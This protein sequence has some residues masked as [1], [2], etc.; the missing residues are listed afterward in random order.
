MNK[1]KRHAISPEACLLCAVAITMLGALAVKPSYA[2]VGATTP[3]TSLEAEAG[4][5]GAG[6]SMVSLTSAPATQFSSPELEASGHAYVR[7]T[8]TGQSVQWTNNT[9]QP[10][11][12]INVR[13]CIPDAPNGGGI[14]AT[15]NLYV[16]GVFRQS[17]N[18]NSKQTWIYE[19]NNNYQGNDQ[20]PADGN[21]HVFWDESHTFITGAPIAP[22]STF[23][24]Q[25]DPSN[26]A[27][28]YYIDVIDVENPPPPL[29]QPANSISIT[30]CGAVADNNPTNGSA[31][32]NTVDSTA[33]IQNCIN[34]AQAQGK[35]LWIPPGTFY[36]KG[37]AGLQATGIT[38][39]GAGMW[40]STIYRAVPLPNSTPLAAVF[41]VT[42]CKVK[43]F[44]I[45][46]NAL[47][48]G[49]KDGDGG[50]MDT[51]G[52]NWLADGMWNQHTESGFWASGTS[53]TVQ[54]SRLTCIWA[55]GI[56]LNNVAL[57]GTVGNNLTATNNFIRG[58]G[59]DALA[60]NSVAYN[61]TSNGTINYTM[62]SGTTFSNNTSVA[63]WQGKGLAIYGGSNQL[64]E[65]NLIQDSGR[66][67][68]L[69][70][71][72]FGVN[73]SDLLSATITG[74]VVLRCG[75]NGFNQGQPAFHIGNGGDG[76]NVGTVTQVRAAGNTIINSI[77]DSFGISTSTNITFE[78]N[79]ITSPGRNGVVIAPPFYQAPTGSATIDGN[80]LTGLKSGQSAFLNNS[81]GYTATVFNNSWQTGGGTE[82][83][84][85][86]T[87]A[88][89]PGTVQA[90]NYDTGGQGIGFNVNTFN[91]TANSYRSDGVDLE[92]TSDTGGG[93]DL[94]WTSPGQ[95]FRYT[96]NVTTAGT[97]TVNFRVAAN[98]AVPGA[99]HLSNSAGTNLSGAITVPATGGWQ[100]WTTVSA[101]VT[102]PAGSQVLTLNEDTGGW[103]INFM[104]FSQGEG[105][106]GGTAAAIPGTVQ[107][108]NYDTGGQGI[109]FNVN[110]FNGT[111]NS[112][113]SDGVDLEA[114]SDTGGGLDLGWTSP[115]QWFRYTVNVTTAGTYTVNFRVAANSAVS[116]A[117]HLSN[118]AGTNLSGAITVP[119]TGGWQTWTT[120]TATVTLPAGSQV[121]TLN[122]DTGG[123][124]I[125]FMTFSQGAEGAF[126][127]TAAAIPGTVQAENYDTGGQ[128]IGYSVNSVNGT[129]KS[130]RSDG[131]DLETT[132]DTGGGL[133]LG[134]TSPGQ[135][136]RYTVNV[137]A[138]G[139]YN[140]QFRVAA[141][142]AVA[143]AFHLSNSAGT[144]LS[145]AVNVP[146]TGGWQTWTTV[147][148]TVTLPAGLQVLTLNEDTGGWNINLFVFAT[149]TVAS[150][151]WVTDWTVAPSIHV[152]GPG[153]DSGLVFNQQTEREIVYTSVGGTSARLH[154]S[155]E[156]GTS[157][158]ALNDIHIA[159]SNGDSSIIA[160]PDRAVTFGG[161]TSVTLP[162][163]AT[164]VSDPINFAVPALANVAVSIFFASNGPITN[165]TSHQFTDQTNFFASG[166]VSATPS[167]S[168]PQ[169]IGN[170]YFLTGLDVQ[171]PSLSASVV[172][173]GASITAG[174]GSTTNA[175]HRWPNLLA[176]RLNAAGKVLGVANMGIPGNRLLSDNGEFGVSAQNRFNRDVL[177]QAGAKFVIFSDDPIND[178]SGDSSL[179]F[180]QFSQ[181]YNSLADQAH[182]HGLK[183]YCS[184]LTPYQGS[185]NWNPQGEATRQ[186]INS[187]I[188]S[189]TSP[190]DGVIDQD[191][192]T[193][194]PSNPTMFL[195]S[196]DSGDHLHPNDAGYQAIA[197][198][199]NLALFN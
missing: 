197:N 179:P 1:L 111:A 49:T 137:A 91:G 104:A 20:N 145:G 121:L 50:A 131:V 113:R 157:P 100:T 102:L 101:T 143:G 165:T 18:L 118:S 124:N 86:G 79:T 120:V 37:T 198:A 46:S 148:A 9:G 183:F 151:P 188:K 171:N 58:T 63:P 6:A 146:A 190:C 154:I 98:S 56:N 125:N 54:N 112:Y 156:Y 97:Y 147:T 15:L 76:Q 193:H 11:T 21:P 94:G 96:V 155:N 59:D 4:T 199:I 114:T 172:A 158:L 78:N 48:R 90:E 67:I 142:S 174:S 52:T 141:I 132:S 107:A 152:L 194:D 19:G 95:W 33:A 136:F 160:S 68:G 166:E 175:N 187:F 161:S 74:N 43:G 99:F 176:Q 22:G 191:A 123:W 77:Y 103:N 178:L 73:G 195:P 36:L 180:S 75:G 30:S 13:E 170:Y 182:S 189:S 72:R 130:Y 70:A 40:Y 69:G 87:A 64:A 5:L 119:A 150:V 108:E 47:S 51:T 169:Q 92:A 41:S 71:G 81:S 192:A 129:A 65:N 39:Q 44:H 177:S 26:T 57:T 135:W 186:Q 138:A 66:Y 7:L 115:G 83:P 16:D 128:G 173:L 140:I 159:Q 34:Q 17:V 60:M 181:A 10:I 164:A 139:T 168:N 144:N 82:G 24:L 8:G 109:A 35:V 80:T 110:T 31:N 62:M 12:F 126:G 29:T 185:G 89:I 32:P 25:M 93:L 134:W 88:P 162:A 38:I 133:D 14:T 127:G 105:A 117:F 61:T 153:G 27:A 2:A 122:E 84:F 116:G 163:G 106:F 149:S 53:G 167:L 3:F 196:F 23:S 28:F 85:G 184:T 42:S 45:D 55:D